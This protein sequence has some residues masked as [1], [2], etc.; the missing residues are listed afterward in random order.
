VG[1][2]QR[3]VLPRLIDLA[4]Q[5]REAARHRRIV[6]PQAS[7]EVLEIGIGSGLNLPFYTTEV[8]AL[9]GLDPSPELLKMAAEAAG[10]APFKVELVERSAEDMPFDDRSFDSVLSSWSLCSVPDAPRA[11]A[12]IRRVLR[13]DGR[14]IF[15]EHGLSSEPAVARWQRRLNRPWGGLTGGCHLDRDMAALIETAGFD[16]DAIET[17]Y[18]IKGPRLL[19]YHFAGQARP[20]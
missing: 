10:G 5:N 4:M 9:V 12:E 15:I 1:F 17:G 14:L 7:G 11:L 8:R 13:P 6:V 3:F 20:G 18:L 19:S 16:L 2:Y